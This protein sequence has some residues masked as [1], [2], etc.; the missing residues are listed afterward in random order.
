MTQWIAGQWIEGQGE[1]FASVSP[2]HG[3]VLWQGFGATLSQ[4]ELAVQAA[5]E[6]FVTWKN[7]PFSEREAL[8]LTFAETVKENSELI[9]ETI[10]K[11]TGKPLWE[12]RTEAAAM[13]GKV[14]ISIQAY[15][16]RTGER[17]KEVNG[18]Q[19]VLRHRPIGVMAVFGPYNFPCHLP[20]GHIIPALLA[21]NTIVFKPSE[22]TPLSGELMV[23]LWQKAGLPAG[24]HIV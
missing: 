10:A 23:R 1:A 14:A 19:V 22:Q 17:A 3:D 7:R 4:V 13:V 2:Y 9:A 16:E 12:T 15:Q 18:N 11:E 20:N 24:G 8:M 21:G 6:A 5:R